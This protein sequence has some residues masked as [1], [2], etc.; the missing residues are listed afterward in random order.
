M[1]KIIFQKAGDIQVNHDDFDESQRMGFRDPKG[2]PQSIVI[3]L[4][5][6]KLTLP[7]SVSDDLNGPILFPF[8]IDF[9]QELRLEIL[10][11]FNTVI[12]PRVEL[13]YPILKDLTRVDVLM[14]PPVI[15]SFVQQKG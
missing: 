14:D 8:E 9:D 7:S 12:I 1:I 6:E 3:D 5:N 15:D 4:L 13:K 2:T 10:N 11:F